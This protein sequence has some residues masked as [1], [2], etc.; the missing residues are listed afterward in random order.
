MR[1]LVDHLEGGPDER[2]NERIR[3][4]RASILNVLHVLAPEQLDSF[5]DSARPLLMILRAEIAYCVKHEKRGTREGGR[6]EHLRAFRQLIEMAIAEVLEA[7]EEIMRARFGPK[8]TANV[9]LDADA[10]VDSSTGESVGSIPAQA[11]AMRAK[12]LSRQR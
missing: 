12:M 1:E 3:V 5:N 6:T 11:R 4:F 8:E 9:S 7:K 2:V 10:I